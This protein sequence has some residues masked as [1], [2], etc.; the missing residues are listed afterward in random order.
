MLF[1]EYT[2]ETIESLELTLILSSI[3][4]QTHLASYPGVISKRTFGGTCA[5]T[6]TTALP[7]RGVL[8]RTPAYVIKTAT[9]PSAR[10]VN[11]GIFLSFTHIEY[12]IVELLFDVIL[13][14]VL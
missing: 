7:D 13:R 9:F 12:L 4:Y 3:T 10:K 8:P 5:G 11:G 6:Q 14:M 1:P 2:D